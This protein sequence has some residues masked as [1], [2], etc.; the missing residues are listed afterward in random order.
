MENIIEVNA[1][2]KIFANQPAIE[3]LSFTVKRG[4]FLVSSDQADLGRPQRLK[5][6]PDNWSRL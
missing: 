1:M 2:A 4:R 3:D 6:L 5:F